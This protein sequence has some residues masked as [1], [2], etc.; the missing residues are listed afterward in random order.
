MG[1]ECCSKC[2]RNVTNFVKCVNCGNIYHNSC[3]TAYKGYKLINEKD[4]ECCFKGNRELITQTSMDEMWK[5]L[6]EECKSK[7]EVLQQNKILLEEKIVTLQ[8]EIDLYKTQIPSVTSNNGMYSNVVKNN[9]Q[10]VLHTKTTNIKKV[11]IPGIVIKSK[12]NETGNNILNAIRSKIDPKKNNIKICDTKLIKDGILINCDT[13]ESTNKLKSNI[14]SIFKDEYN[15]N[16]KNKFNPRLILRNVILNMSDTDFLD[17]L[18]TNND[19]LGAN[20]DNIKLIKIFDRGNQKNI[21]IE[22]TAVLRQ[23]ILDADGYLYT[24]WERFHI[25]DYV[26]VIRCFKCHKFGHTRNNCK[27]KAQVCSEC[28]ENHS[29]DV[30]PATVKRCPNCVIHNQSLNN[31][32][33]ELAT[34]HSATAS[35]CKIFLN[36]YNY[37]LNKLC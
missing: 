3:A 29:K 6:Y 18:I 35:N 4:V 13:D 8:K 31:K 32:D 11:N 26:H 1:V 28:G 9:I 24:S 21:I 27:E 17:D 37:L 7:N 23:N 20:K 2:K 22:T 14:E 5:K 36:H 19:H 16:I 12:S 25:Q 33:N 10:P 30:C 15:V 34:D